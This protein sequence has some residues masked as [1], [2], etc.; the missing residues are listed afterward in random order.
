[1]KIRKFEARN[2]TE[3]LGMIKRELGQDAIILSSTETGRGRVEVTAAV[4]EAVSTASAQARHAVAARKNDN[5]SVN[6][7]VADG[8]ARAYNSALKPRPIYQRPAQ[9]LGRD[10]SQEAAAQSPAGDLSAARQQWMNRQKSAKPQAAASTIQ[11]TVNEAL[12]SGSLAKEITELRESIMAMQRSGYAM[13][14]PAGKKDMFGA[15][16]KNAVNEDLALT[17]CERAMKPS[18]LKGLLTE[19]IRTAPWGAGK[20][21]IMVIGPTGVGKTTTVAKLAARAIRQGKRVALVNLDTYRIGAVEQIRI[22]A[23]ILGVPLETAHDLDGLADALL[24]HSDKDLVFIDT[25]GRNPR[26]PKYLEEL[27][28]IT[29]LGFPIEIH[30]LMS[31]SSDEE[32]LAQSCRR[33]SGLPIDLL[34]VTKADEAFRFGAIYN[35]STITGRP[36]AYITTGQ[37]VPD[38]IVFPT[39]PELV[40]MVMGESVVNGNSVEVSTCGVI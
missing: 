22:Y 31:A 19:G 6:L 1:M 26:D 29:A 12:P 40:D 20:K 28:G 24:T 21:A 35:M 18:D 27:N 16:R 5:I 25:T 36:V 2:F 8:P 39:A 15:L 38:D 7:A 23:R 3:A 33:Y 4:D 34:G 11:P 37:K 14:L 13:S 9:G 17:L 32:F 10:S 30:L